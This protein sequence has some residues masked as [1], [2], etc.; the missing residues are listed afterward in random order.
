MANYPRSMLD[1]LARSGLTAADADRMHL[2]YEPFPVVRT[3]GSK[4]QLVEAYRIPYQAPDGTDWPPRWK[5]LEPYRAKGDKHDRKYMQLPSTSPHFYLPPYFEW[6]KVA[7]DPELAL[8]FVEGEKKAAAICKLGLPA[9][10]IAGVWNWLVEGNAIEDFA[11]FKFFWRQTYL[12]FDSDAEFKTQVHLARERLA[13]LLIRF[14]SR[15]VLCHLPTLPGQT[16]TGADDFCVFHKAKAKAELLKLPLTHLFVPPGYNALEL[17]NT[18]LPPP[19]W[20]IPNLLVSGLTVLAGPPKAGKSWFALTLALMVASGSSGFG[21]AYKAKQAEV[22]YIPLEDPDVRLQYRIARLKKAGLVVTSSLE[23]RTTWPRS[24]H[25]GIEALE[26]W[27]MQHPRCRVAII[28]TL[29]LMRAARTRDSDLYQYDADTMRTF[30]HLADRY[31]V[32][33]VLVHHLNKNINAGIFDRFSGSSGLTGGADTLIA[34]DPKSVTDTVLEIKGRDLAPQSLM[35]FTDDGLWT[36]LGDAALVQAEGRQ[37]ALTTA[38]KE[39]TNPLTLV[40]LRDLTGQ[41]RQAL[42]NALTSLIKQGLVVKTGRGSYQL[43][44]LIEAHRKER[45]Y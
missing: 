30:K 33:I 8:W 24:D 41:S 6:A 23:L 44:K 22:L 39:A 26:A 5:L 40:E 25:Y 28:D 42:F 35:M 19:R 18:K 15:A 16:K 3:L 13:D 36:V 32:A 17:L 4:P 29:V 10:A 20:V 38:L 7:N 14:K 1:D 34:F 37:V 27:F 31:G 21:G 9:L 11:L 12:L 2:K 43:T 45:K